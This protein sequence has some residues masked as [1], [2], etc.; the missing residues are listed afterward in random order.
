MK[1]AVSIP[2]DVFEEAEGLARR[3]KASRSEVYSRALSEFLG[4]HAPEQ[5]TE[6]MN[7]VAEDVGVEEPDTFRAKAARRVFERTEW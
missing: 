2:D 5:I 4:R 7:R 6:R 3:L 1:V